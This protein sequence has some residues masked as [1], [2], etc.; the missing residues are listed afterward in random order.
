MSY[1]KIKKMDYKEWWCFF[2]FL[3]LD[4]IYY[5]RLCKMQK[6]RMIMKFF[7]ISE[8]T[9]RGQSISCLPLTADSP[10]IILKTPYRES[11][12]PTSTYRLLVKYD[13]L[14]HNLSQSWA[15]LC[16]WAHDAACTSVPLWS[17]ALRERLFAG[18]CDI[19]RFVFDEFKR[20]TG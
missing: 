4:Q 18:K 11:H 1:W 2:L 8:S 6:S 5:T 7:N 17:C 12:I 3:L 13:M 20:V 9:R 16:V 14:V 10:F 19:A 15:K